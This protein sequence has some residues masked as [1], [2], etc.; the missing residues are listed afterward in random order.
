MSIGNTWSK[1]ILDVFFSPLPSTILV[2]E[3]AVY[4]T[5][6]T[7]S[8]STLNEEPL[9]ALRLEEASLLAEK[10]RMHLSKIRQEN[11]LGQSAPI[12]L[13]NTLKTEA[14][15]M[16]Q[17][18]L[19]IFYAVNHIINTKL[20]DGHI[21]TS[22][23]WTQTGRMRADYRWT[24]YPPS[25]EPMPFAVLELKAP[26]LIDWEGD[27]MPAIAKTAEEERD[28]LVN[29]YN[30]PSGTLLV[31]N[32]KIFI[33]QVK[34][35][36]NNLGINDVAIFDWNTL[37]VLDIEGLDEDSRN[38]R[39]ARIAKFEEAEYTRQ[40]AAG[41]TFNMMMLGFLLRAMDRYPQIS[42]NL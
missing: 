22:S 24:Y 42:F 23:E 14:D 27:F 29:A 9:R 16:G 21:E 37:I 31:Q 4:R 30:E 6:A 25:G 18:I 41:M 10:G 40:F 12:P 5:V 38:H 33:Q 1:V 15:V 19:H 26:N 2:D 32:A 20:K 36:A 3:A 8:A 39:L 34:K 28:I 13:R 11:I 7:T 17:S 35:Y